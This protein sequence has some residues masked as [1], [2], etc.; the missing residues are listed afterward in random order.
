MENTYIKYDDIE[1]TNDFIQRISIA[2][3]GKPEQRRRGRK[4]APGLERG[5]GQ[6]VSPKVS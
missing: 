5:K 3:W 4:A 6:A 2:V 1:I